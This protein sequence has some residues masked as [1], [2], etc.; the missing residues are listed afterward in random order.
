MKKF[1]FGVLCAA[2]FSTVSADM[3]PEKIGENLFQ[4]R[5]KA[6]VDNIGSDGGDESYFRLTTGVPAG[7]NYHLMYFSNSTSTGKSMFAMLLQAQAAGIPVS[8]VRYSIHGNVC[9]VNMIGIGNSSPGYE[10]P[11]VW[12]R[13]PDLSHTFVVDPVVA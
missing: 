6:W 11:R 13:A 1:L 7:C 8:S 2:L 12:R 10:S 5:P 3:S 9:R 4:I